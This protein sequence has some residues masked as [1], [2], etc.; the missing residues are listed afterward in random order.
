MYHFS[1]QKLWTLPCL[2]LAE[3]C[4]HI[5]SPIVRAIR[6][7]IR[8]DS[9]PKGHL[10]LYVQPD[11]HILLTSPFNITRQGIPTQSNIAFP[12][13]EVW[14][15]CLQAFS[16]VSKSCKTDFL[17]K[18]CMSRTKYRWPWESPN[19][20]R[21]SCPS[22]LTQTPLEIQQLWASYLRYRFCLFCLSKVLLLWKGVAT[23]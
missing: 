3:Q 12:R 13:V 22:S 6:L 23:F 4:K 14:K 1:P 21:L 16:T 5:V 8:T 2:H 11:H 19:N 10:P 7:P 20:Q 9:S 18:S 17:P 15:W